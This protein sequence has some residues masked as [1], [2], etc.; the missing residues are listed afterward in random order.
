MT[1]HVKTAYRRHRRGTWAAVLVVLGAA[2]LA[3]VLPAVAATGDE[4]PPQSA[5]LQVMPTEN[6]SGGDTFQ[7]NSLPGS[8]G[9]Y[10][11][12]FN[13]PRSTTI[14]T[15]ANGKPVSITIVVANTP[16]AVKDKYLSFK[17]VGATVSHVA[18]NGGTKTAIYDYTS[19][20]GVSADGHG[21][22]TAGVTVDTSPSGTGAAAGT[23][24]HA[25]SQDTSSTSPS[26]LYALSYTTFCFDPSGSISGTV[27]NDLNGD[28]TQTASA[29]AEPGQGGWTVRAYNASGIEV[30]SDTTNA[31]GAY[32]F[33]NLPLGQTYTICEE[34]PNPDSW[35]G[36][37]I[38]TE[39]TTT[40]ANP[41]CRTGDGEEPTGWQVLLNESATKNF[42]NQ[43]TVT[44]SCSEP[45]S[46]LAFGGTVEYEAQLELK[47]GECKDDDLVMF[48][49]KDG[50]DLFATLHPVTEP[51]VPDF[52]RVV[53][54][55]TWEGV[56]SASDPYAQNP[57]TLWY[58]DIAPYDGVD[59]PGIAGNDG[60]WTMKLCKQDPRT[61]DFTLDPD[62]DD[63]DILPTGETTCMI[64][65]TDLAG[66]KYEAWL[67]SN[68]DGSRGVI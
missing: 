33:A 62:I 22:G 3:T 31:N 5:P 41:A 37:W 7:C 66:D 36:G 16:R 67:F 4:I 57:V 15:T 24:L 49:Y 26:V 51:N 28:G 54:H 43:A 55:I 13:N 17:V 6:P 19:L 61:G 21:A 1:Q 27:Y 50:D 35:G 59:T 47:D 60:K 14:N 11:Y 58:D 42:G 18:I 39:P 65:S 45:F 20:G 68:V 44:P 10:Q 32:S 40:P 34:R 29:P 9:A 12:K 46:G 53:E 2:A 30:A 48:T 8:H 52:F 64:L 56:A 23:G 63:A 25:T 38:Q